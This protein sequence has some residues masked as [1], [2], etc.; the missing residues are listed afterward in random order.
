MFKDKA[1]V[2]GNSRALNGGG[3]SGSQCDNGHALLHTEHQIRGNG[4][5]AGHPE[6]GTLSENGCTLYLPIN[7]DGEV[8]RAITAHY[9]KEG[10]TNFVP[11]TNSKIKATAI[12]IRY[13]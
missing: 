5:S 7:T 8:C 4:T 9:H 1:T 2:F 3:N 13:D 6:P 12:L 10:W 11:D